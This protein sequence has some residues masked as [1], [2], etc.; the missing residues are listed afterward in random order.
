MNKLKAM[1]AALALA[2][3]MGGCATTG[4]AGSAPQQAAQ[5]PRINRAIQVLASGQPVYYTQPSA[6]GYEDGRRLAATQADYITYDMEHGAFS[7]TELRAFMQG[8]VD[9]G[10]TRTGHRT[11]AVIVTLPALGDNA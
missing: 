3:G 5:T 8:L 7:I 9:A 2:A 10:P 1:A 6:G 4:D 11:P